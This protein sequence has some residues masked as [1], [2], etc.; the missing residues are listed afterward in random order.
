MWSWLARDASQDGPTAL[1]ITRTA[2][3]ID[4]ATDTPET[5]RW[6]VVHR[7]GFVTD[8]SLI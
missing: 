8:C 1:A 3:P 7:Q 2:E 5:G 6:K 4:P